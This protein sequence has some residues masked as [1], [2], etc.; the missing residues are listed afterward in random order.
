MLE[1]LLAGIMGMIGLL[2]LSWSLGGSLLLDKSSPLVEGKPLV[3]L[4]RIQCL[5]AA[6]AMF[7]LAAVP[8]VAMRRLL[9]ESLLLLIMT[10]FAAR[11][12][13]DFRYAGFSKKVKDSAFAI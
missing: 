10:A 6:A 8:V 3:H 9:R 1:W 4:S 12:F 2:Y 7:L 11:A 13:G 5:G